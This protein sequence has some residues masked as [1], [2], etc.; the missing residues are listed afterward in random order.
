MQEM[1]TVLLS[2]TLVYSERPKLCTILAFLS[3]IGL[4]LYF[5][6]LTYIVQAFIAQQIKH[7]P[8]DLANFSSHK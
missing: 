1:Y 8:T 5:I 2:L 7:R 4:K 3:P 6:I